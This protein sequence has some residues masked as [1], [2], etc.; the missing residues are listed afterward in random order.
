VLA[1]SVDIQRVLLNLVLNAAQAVRAP[2]G[3]IEIGVV[4]MGPDFVRLTVADNG[5]GMTQAAV[6]S[7]L[8]S[9]SRPIAG[10]AGVGFGLWIVNQLVQGH[11]GRLRIESEP[12]AGTTVRIDWP[13][14]REAQ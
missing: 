2:L 9:F 4:G 6:V 10:R 5:V 8:E 7:L 1:D 14:A 11:G 12:G 3:V 13:A